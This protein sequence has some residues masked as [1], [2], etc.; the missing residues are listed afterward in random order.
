MRLGHC[1]SSVT[2][3]GQDAKN[4]DNSKRSFPLEYRQVSIN[5]ETVSLSSLLSDADEHKQQTFAHG[6]PKP[7]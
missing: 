4:G 1:D 2:A 7:T 3:A 6:C 5:E